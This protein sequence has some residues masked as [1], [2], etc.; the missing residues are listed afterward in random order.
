MDPQIFTMACGD[1]IIKSQGYA[2]VNF[3]VQQQNFTATFQIIESLNEEAILGAPF[4]FNEHVLVDYGRKCLY[5][6]K[7]ER[8]TVYWDQANTTSTTRQPLH[9]SVHIPEKYQSDISGIFEEFSDLFT[10]ELTKATTVTTQ[11]KINLT[12]NTPVNIRPYPMSPDKKKILYE[13][14]QE[15]L[16]AGV[17]ESSTAPYSSP[18][19]IVERPNKKPRF[20]VDYRKLNEKTQDEASTLPKIYETIKDFGDATIFT[21]LDLKSGYWQV[22]MHPDSKPYTTFTT[23]DGAAYQFTVMPF[24]LKTAPSTFQN[25]MARDVLTGYL[26]HFVQVYLDDIIVYSPNIKQHKTD[27]KLVFERLRIH[28]LKISPEKCIIATDEL[29]YLGHHIQ[30]TLTLP[31]QKHVLAVQN[32]PAPATKKQLQSFLGLC[33]WIREYVPRAAQLTIP[34]T[35]LLRKDVKF[36]WTAE[37]QNAFETLKQTISQ[38]LELH[39]PNFKKRFYLQTD[40][41]LQGISGVLFQYDE[42]G[43][44]NVVSYASSSLSNAEKKYHINEIECLAIVTFIKKYKIYL[45]DKPFTL[46]TDNRSLLWLDKNK[47]AKTKL[48]RWSL[49][50]QEYSFNMEHCPGKENELPDFL[51]RNPENNEEREGLDLERMFP[52]E[53]RNFKNHHEYD[54]LQQLL[55]SDLQDD[56]ILAQQQSRRIQQNIRK[57]QYIEEN[58]AEGQS[59]RNFHANHKYHEGIFWRT[60]QGL[61]KIVVPNN[62]IKQVIKHFHDE[63]QA[64]HPGR[65]ET[66]RTITRKYHWR[67]LQRMVA[68]YINKCLICKSVKGR[69]LQPSAPFKA[70]TPTKN[71]EMLSIDILGPYQESRTHKNRYIIMVEDVFSKWVEAKAYTE[72]KSKQVV[73]FLE[74]EVIARYG[75]PYCIISDNGGHFNSAHYKQWCLRN[76]IQ[77]SYTAVYHQRANPIERRVQEF[78]K[79]LRTLMYRKPTNTWDQYI[80]RALY[81]LRTRRNA[82]TNF[83]PSQMVL[84]YEMPQPGEWNLPQYQNERE[85]H[86]AETHADRQQRAQTRQEQYQNKYA[87]LGAQP[88]VIFQEGDM[89]MAKVLRKRQDVFLP[90]W[91]G[92]HRITR[93]ISDEIYEVERDLKRTRI[94]VDNLRPAPPMDDD[95]ELPADTES[96]SDRYSDDDESSLADDEISALPRPV[97]QQDVNADEQPSD[98]TK[99]DEEI[100]PRGEEDNVPLIPRTVTQNFSQ[101]TRKLPTSERASV[102]GQGTIP[103]NLNPSTSQ[104]KSISLP[105]ESTSHSAKTHAKATQSSVI[106]AS[107]TTLESSLAPSEKPEAPLGG[108]LPEAFRMPTRRIRKPRHCIICK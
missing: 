101:K 53:Y 14:V 11:H 98:G 71:F 94:H 60:H 18:P 40:G 28:N 49:L 105:H 70:H 24:G 78:K 69:Q 4:L 56:V 75:V 85:V 80:N 103:Q 39:R 34:L 73:K 36:K 13:Q 6:G 102:S 59:D 32:F 33:N 25:L 65:D 63:Q 72:V 62:K 46:R 3:S 55:V 5:M 2:E 86:N 19:V 31:Q 45:E 76:N 9:N 96:D 84:G 1:N 95:D 83:T 106:P 108:Q 17:I 21:L 50:L 12:D 51:S 89:V 99:Q 81:V 87:P 38:P 23:P 10:D 100:P 58:G 68:D 88:I 16:E 91:T 54:N 104:R 66:V 22:P 64:S 90:V 47:D 48:T 15:M 26:H 35:N 20:C 82:A 92:P 107:S 79:V 30:G 37:C 44:R 52:P 7:T 43:N 41:S 61:D 93:K 77:V 97:S 8:K 27:L 74:D 29:D 42:Q 57:W 67:N